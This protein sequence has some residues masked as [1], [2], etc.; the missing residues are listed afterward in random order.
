MSARTHTG[1]LGRTIA[2]AGA[3]LMAFTA[4]VATAPAAGADD[5]ERTSSEVIAQ[6]EAQP[7]PFYEHGDVH[8]DIRAA[9]R[10]L[11]QLEYKSE[12]ET[13]EFTDEL[14]EQVEEYQADHSQYLPETGDLDDETWLLLREQTYGNEYVPGDGPDNGRT[15]GV[16]GI[17]EILQ[18]KHG[19]DIDN[20]GWYG[21]ETFYAVCDA[22]ESYGMD[23][24]G[25]VGR[26]TWRALI[27]DQDWDQDAARDVSAAEV[28]DQPPMGFVADPRAAAAQLD[29]SDDRP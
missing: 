6:I 27:T 1:L 2:V 22:Q 8:I 21:P 10:A 28:P 19:A 25:L 18:V 14:L 29:C 4:S 20:D 16:L 13:S 26:I 12:V 9:Y 11:G 24:D 7:W 17:Q 3:G 5:L 23:P 15:W